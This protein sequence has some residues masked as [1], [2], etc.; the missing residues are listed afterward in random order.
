MRYAYINPRFTYLLNNNLLTYT[1][2]C[3]KR[4]R[5]ITHEESVYVISLRIIKVIYVAIEWLI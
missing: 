2:H 5:E 4:T 3:T 1:H